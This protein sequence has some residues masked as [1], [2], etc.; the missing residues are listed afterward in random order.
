MC[1]ECVE[2]CGRGNSC[3]Q[4][5]C[6]VLA[7]HIARRVV[8]AD[9]VLAVV[10]ATVNTG[11]AQTLGRDPHELGEVAGVLSE[12]RVLEVVEPDLVVP[13]CDGRGGVIAQ[14]E[15]LP[16]RPARVHECAVAV[17]GVCVVLGVAGELRRPGESR[18]VV[19][20]AVGVVLEKDL[21]L[22]RRTCCGGQR[23][24][25]RRCGCRCHRQRR[26]GARRT[27]GR[28][29]HGAKNG[30]SGSDPRWRGLAGERDGSGE[31]AGCQ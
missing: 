22:E 14:S 6:L 29:P 8:A 20:G 27:G 16:V 28:Q 17:V 11:A 15:I 19:K 24:C 3:F 13:G 5:V 25:R 31:R 10:V 4:D 26:R 9:R 23:R 21:G 2:A 30:G 1:G 12:A 18:R 7:R